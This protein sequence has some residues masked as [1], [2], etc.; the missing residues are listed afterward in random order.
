[1]DEIPTNRK[2]L[3]LA[4]IS[5]NQTDNHIKNSKQSIFLSGRTIVLKRTFR[6]DYKKHFE[7]Q[8]G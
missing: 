5:F 8:T 2:M 1:M 3:S 7:F 6:L 4:G